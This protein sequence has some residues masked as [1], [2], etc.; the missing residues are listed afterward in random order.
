MLIA[1]YLVLTVILVYLIKRVQS[2]PG[3]KVRVRE[4]HTVALTALSLKA[5]YAMDSVLY[6]VTEKRNLKR[7]SIWLEKD[8][9]AA[10][11]FRIESYEATFRG[12]AD[13]LAA[14]EGLKPALADLFSVLQ[15]EQEEWQR[16]LIT[17]A[18]GA[19][20]TSTQLTFSWD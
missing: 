5:Q 10:G 15:E 4:P 13:E 9:A 17:T 1:F 7:A 18:A 3:E 16:V 12:S 11:G 20:S 6:R 14:P 2:K 8:A 19:R